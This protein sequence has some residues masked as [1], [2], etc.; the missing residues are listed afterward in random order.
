MENKLSAAQHNTYK[1]RKTNRW[2]RDQTKFKDIMEINKNRKCTWA[3]GISH[4]TDNTLLIDVVQH[5]QFGY[6]SGPGRF[7]LLPDVL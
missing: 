6:P 5:P 7:L 3:C 4:I 1:D 2:M